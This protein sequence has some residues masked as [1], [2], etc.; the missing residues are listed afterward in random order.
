[1][2][3]K[4]LKDYCTEELVLKSDGTNEESSLETKDGEFLDPVNQVE[5]KLDS[6]QPG[7]EACTSNI[8]MVVMNAKTESGK[9]PVLKLP[10][11]GYIKDLKATL[12]VTKEDLKL[13]KQCENTA[14]D[15]D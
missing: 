2:V 4:E 3:K 9:Y 11:K 6:I 5:I 14:L 1:M 12:L 15:G 8:T 13:M 10:I 7:F